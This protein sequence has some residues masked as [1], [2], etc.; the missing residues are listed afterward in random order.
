M[1]TYKTRLDH[2]RIFTDEEDLLT[3]YIA[4]AAKMNYGFSKKE[5]RVLA[6][7]YTA[8]NNKA[9]P[10][11]WTEKKIAGEEWIEDRNYQ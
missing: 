1:Y 9:V 7:N 4:T 5:V 6:Y 3:I 2:K 11:N 10:E 8:L